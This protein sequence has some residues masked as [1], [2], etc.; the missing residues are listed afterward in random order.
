MAALA[1]LRRRKPSSACSN[2]GGA[3][4]DRIDLVGETEQA[5][6]LQAYAEVDLGLDPFPYS[7][8]VTTL[9]AMWMGVPSVTFVG[10]T[11]AGRHSA[12]HLTAA[13]LGRFCANTIDDYVAMAVSWSR[14]Q[15]ELAELRAGLRERV[16][17]SRSAMRRALRK[18]SCVSWSGCGRTG[19]KAAAWGSRASKPDAGHDLPYCPSP[20]LEAFALTQTDG[21]RA[22]EV[23]RA[24]VDRALTLFQK[25]RFDSAE[26]LLATIAADAT[27]KPMV[28]HLRGSLRCISGRRNARSNFFGRPS[29]PIR[30]IPKRTQ[31]WPSSA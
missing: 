6:L 14:R 3:P 26:V 20:D 21:R 2:G 19:V 5:K 29:A 23:V 24:I 18:I 30:P 16:A 4:R 13:G 1:R 15:G 8:G 25:G 12:T 7:G 27:V 9:E 31:I 17:A 28:L 10:E 22:P 11:F